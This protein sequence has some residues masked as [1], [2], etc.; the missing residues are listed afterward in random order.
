M[1]DNI[2]E[3]DLDTVCEILAWLWTNKRDV[4]EYKELFEVNDLGFPLAYGYYTEMIGIKSP[5]EKLIRDTWEYTIM[6]F[7]F[8]VTE[9]FTSLLDFVGRFPDDFSD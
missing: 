3:Q 6:G 8:P 1:A 9:K 4:E 2:N 7:D 5:A